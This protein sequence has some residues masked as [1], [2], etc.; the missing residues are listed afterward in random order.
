MR[1]DRDAQTPPTPSWLSYG[2]ATYGLFA[3]IATGGMATVHLAGV[4]RGERAPSVVAIKRLHDH[5]SADPVMVAMFNN[6]ARILSRIRHPNVVSLLDFFERRGSHY[7]VMEYVPGE[8][9]ARLLTAPAPAPI[10]ARIVVDLLYGL[11][12][13]HSA[14]DEHGKLLGV[15]HRDVSPANVLVGED[16]CTRALDFG[17]AKVNSQRSMTLVGEVKG[18][19]AYIAPEHIAGGILSPRTDVYS[20]G[21]VLWEALVGRR[22]FGGKT[23][24]DVFARVVEGAVQPPS[25]QVAGITDAL[26]AIVLQAIASDPTRRFATAAAFAEALETHVDLASRTVVAKWLQSRASERLVHRSTIVADIVEELRAIA[27]PSGDMSVISTLNVHRA[28]LYKRQHLRATAGWPSFAAAACLM[29]A[30][31]ALLGD[32]LVEKQTTRSTGYEHATTA[33]GRRSAGR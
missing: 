28:E 12:A 27:P 5:L 1:V 4:A 21:V 30:I 19:P 16:G 23:E 13:A 7:L 3:A 25:S 22:L 10:A 20:A 9:L 26:D 29:A 32:I 11:E 17:I 14:R 31:S 18:K 33:I 2:N 8:S 6:E 15:V 24:H